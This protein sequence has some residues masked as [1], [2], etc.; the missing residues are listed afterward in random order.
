MRFLAKT[1][2]EKSDDEEKPANNSLHFTFGSE[3][4]NRRP[5]LIPRHYTLL[6]ED[7]QN[8]YFILRLPI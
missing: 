1:N 8:F 2:D 4:Q 7:E 6:W 3:T 5:Y